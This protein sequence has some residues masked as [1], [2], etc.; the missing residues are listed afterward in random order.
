MLLK[1]LEHLEDYV[2]GTKGDETFIR[3]SSNENNY[4]PSPKVVETI[5]KSHP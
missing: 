2:S 5:K 4:G 3:L 1:N